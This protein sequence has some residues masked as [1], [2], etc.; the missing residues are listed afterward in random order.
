MTMATAAVVAV[1]VITNIAIFMSNTFG[2]LFKLTTFGESHGPAVGGVV[3]GMPPG[4]DIDLH[5]IQQE[6]NR[7]RPGQSAITT[8]RQEADQVEL[9]SGVFEGKSTGCPIG[10]IVR[11]QNQHSQDYENMRTLFRPSHA[12]YTYYAKYGLRDHRGGGRSSARITISR[13]VGGALAK[14]VLQQYGISIQAYTSQVGTIA[15]DRDYRRYDLSLAEQNAVRCPDPEKA[16]AME[17]LITQVKAEGD[18]I[19]GVITC[20]ISG[21]P[22]GLGEPE[23]GK[24]HAALGSAMLSINAV[25]GFEYGDGFD[26]VAARGSQVNDVFLPVSAAAASAVPASASPASPAAGFSV[27]SG[28]AAALPAPLATRTNHSGGIQGGISNGQ[29]IYFRVAFKPV[30]T[31]LR[32]QDTVDMEGNATTLTARG[33]HDPCVLPRAV[34]IVEAMAAMTILDAILANNMVKK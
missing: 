10:F 14:L 28:S 15:L 16:A 25:K 27:G 29:D 13:C 21:C 26:G 22:P 23:F 31:L 8:A 4:I 34:P 5:F 24:L 30:A 32:Q 12:D 19:G 11:N 18:T 7:R 3:D 33:R 17:A 1:A 20:V 6:L 9:L 2:Q